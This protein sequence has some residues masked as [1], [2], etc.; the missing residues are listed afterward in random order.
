MRPV[1]D[2][3][4]RLGTDDLWRI[5]LLVVLALV[6]RALYFAQL[7]VP[8]YDPW[9]HLA[10]VRNLRSGLGFTLFDGQPYLWYSPVWYV[11]C[12]AVP[13]WL[14]M[15]WLAG[16]FSVLAVPALYLVGRRMSG[17]L[18]ASAAAGL[19]AA[20]GPVVAFT[21]H[22]GPEALAL[23][24]TLG[25]LAL[26]AL[27]GGVAAALVSGLAI[28]MATV[29][30]TH[31]AL[32]ACL[33]LPWVREPRRGAAFVAGI[34]VP[35]GATWWRNHL[36]LESHTWVFTWDGLATRS[37]GFDV[38]STLVVQLHPSIQEGLRRLHEIVVPHPEWL[39]RDGAP[40]WP[41]I[42][43]FLSGLLCVVVAR[44]A[45]L[46]LAALVPVA[47]FLLLDRSLSA[48]FFRIY[49]PVFPALFLAIGIVA[50]RLAE[51]RGWLAV[52]VLAIPVLGG[53]PLLV[54]PAIGSL[55]ALTPP[56]G[57]LSERAYLVPSG[58][59]HPESLVWRF[60][61]QRFLGLPLEPEDL[62]DFLSAYPE[63]RAVLLHDFTVQPE[64]ERALIDDPAWRLTR[65]VANPAGRVYRVLVRAEAG[66][67]NAP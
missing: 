48:N 55:E 49:L 31:F 46:A 58:R 24:L 36:I 38:L 1:G 28:G 30:R 63:Y 13:S 35:L 11:L 26:V 42:A 66:G 43:F 8:Q 6:V 23:F 41:V 64:V 51:R 20:C 50:E 39:V 18:A 7:D 25:G 34:A 15:E 60:P 37:S 40:N 12:A 33:A 45:T 47:F 4:A 54:P 29:L 27:R 59:F 2:P 10:L 32:D 53:A 52:V 16:A 56:P 19:L 65:A 14:R 57:L 17:V 67:T 21:C 5:A 62:P 9:R 44:R 22:Y 3:P 61:E